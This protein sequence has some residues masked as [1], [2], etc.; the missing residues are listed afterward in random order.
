M[1]VYADL[2][3]MWLRACLAAA[4]A[5][6]VL[7]TLSAHDRISTKVTWDGEV[8]RIVEARCV[9]CHTAGGRAPMPLRT[10]AD[11]RPWARAIK[12]EVL[13]RRMPK[14]HAARGYGDLANDPSLSPF[15]IALIASWVDG[16]APERGLT[17]STSTAQL[18]A[19]T[20]GSTAN[21]DGQ[22]RDTRTITQPCGTE[23]LPGGRLLAVR[24]RLAKGASAGV[25]V[26]LPDGEREIVVWV[27]R[28]EPEFSETYV[29]RRPLRTVPGSR[30]LVEPAA[31]CVIDLLFD[32]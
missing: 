22:L 29:L 21:T 19:S 30:L 20:A 3:R 24:P 16:G 2:R 27:R 31:D 13:T 25:A 18:P 6:G 4:G 26:R 7:A 23:R 8:S 1:D 28:Y 17:P 32:R 5:M 12:E 11:A 9:A 10:Y 14:W 15:E